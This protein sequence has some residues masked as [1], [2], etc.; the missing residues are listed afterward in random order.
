MQEL[1]RPVDEVRSAL[2][3]HHAVESHLAWMDENV[4]GALDLEA[5]LRP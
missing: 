3:S 5:L 2:G 4:A 1:A